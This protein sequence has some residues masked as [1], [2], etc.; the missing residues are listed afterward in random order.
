VKLTI[1]GGPVR[2]R[3]TRSAT[4]VIAAA[5]VW[6]LANYVLTTRE[7]KRLFGFIG[8]GAISGNIVGGFVENVAALGPT[9]ALTGPAARGDE[10]TIRRHLRA[11]PA[12]ERRTIELEA[13]SD[14]VWRA[15]HETTLGEL[16]V[17]RTLA[18]LDG[19][20]GQH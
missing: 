15:I 14:C 16:R 2:C 5:Q 18:D 17:A 7:A 3:A 12:D 1:A 4:G 10:A 11:L 19:A 20:D 6:T 9:R 8:S 13:P